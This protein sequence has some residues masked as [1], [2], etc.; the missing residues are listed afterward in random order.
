MQISLKLSRSGLAA[1]QSCQR[2]GCAKALSLHNLTC[3]DAR[4]R[5]QASTP[6]VKGDSSMP[7]QGRM[8]S[9]VPSGPWSER[10]E[11]GG[12]SHGA[13]PAIGGTGPTDPP[14]EPCGRLASDQSCSRTRTHAWSA[15]TGLSGQSAYLRRPSEGPRVRGRRSQPQSSSFPWEVRRNS[16]HLSG[17]VS[18]PVEQAVLIQQTTERSKQPAVRTAACT[19]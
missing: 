18:V 14:V 8:P 6:R 19:T 11:V 12:V 16:Y 17:T 9:A 7:G 15:T 1:G 2:Q 3:R 10:C 4:R 5:E 13:P